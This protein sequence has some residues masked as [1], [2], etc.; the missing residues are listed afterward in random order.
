MATYQETMNLQDIFL[1]KCMNTLVCIALFYVHKRI[2]LRIRQR[3]ENLPKNKPPT[4][5]QPPSCPSLKRDIRR[6]IP[7]ILRAIWLNCVRTLHKLLSRSAKRKKKQPRARKNNDSLLDLSK[8][9]VHIEDE[10]EDVDADHI[11]SCGSQL[12]V[13]SEEEITKLEFVPAHWEVHIYHKRTYMCPNCEGD[14][15]VCKPILP[16]ELDN[17]ALP[18]AYATNSLLSEILFDKFAC[19]LPLYRQTMIFDELGATC[20][21]KRWSDGST[22]PASP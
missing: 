1:L 6:A 15:E 19:V 9:I 4:L 12:V 10:P 16:S 22:K 8:K 21:G 7:P 2:F 14:E 11:C 17:K 18:E 13:K 20:K 5:K 3:E